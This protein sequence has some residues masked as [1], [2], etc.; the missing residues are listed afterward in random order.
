[1]STDP[2]CIGI[3]YYFECLSSF[4]FPGAGI[5]AVVFDPATGELNRLDVDFRAYLSELGDIYDLAF[6]EPVSLEARTEAEQQEAR[7]DQA[8]SARTCSGTNDA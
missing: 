4:L 2:F 6:D 8:V 3:S 7:R 5:H 1:M